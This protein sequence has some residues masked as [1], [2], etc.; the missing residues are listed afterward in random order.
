MSNK[1]ILIIT[2][3]QISKQS[4]P[5][6]YFSG[7]IGSVFTR[8]SPPAFAYISPS[9]SVGTTRIP[10]QSGLLTTCEFQN[11]VPHTS[12]ISIA[13]IMPCIQKLILKLC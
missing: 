11:K 9:R 6:E 4:K 3:F 8:T 2:D 5:T 12:L 7:A 13:T 10:A 1:N